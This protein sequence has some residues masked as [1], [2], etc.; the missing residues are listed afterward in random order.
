MFQT[1]YLLVNVCSDNYLI[2]HAILSY[3]YLLANNV[4]V[5]THR[6]KNLASDVVHTCCE[7]KDQLCHRVILYSSDLLA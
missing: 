4:L 7:A 6:F 1:S 5:G 3:A 2:L